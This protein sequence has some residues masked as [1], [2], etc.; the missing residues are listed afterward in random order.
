M[1]ELSELDLKPVVTETSGTPLRSDKPRL[2]RR[3]PVASLLSLLPL[4]RCSRDLK[5]PERNNQRKLLKPRPPSLL[6]PPP[7]LLNEMQLL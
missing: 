5:D 3:G 1:L 7:S 6:K 2:M 4:P